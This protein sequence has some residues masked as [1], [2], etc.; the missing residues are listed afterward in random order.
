M[1]EYKHQNDFFLT[2]S[3][4]LVNPVNCVGVSGKGLALEFK[5]RYPDNFKKYQEKCHKK[6]LIIG[7]IYLHKTDLDFPKH[8]LNVPTKIHWKNK[9]E[10]SFIMKGI[11]AIC[12]IIKNYEIKSINIPALGCGLGGLEKDNV[13]EIII[14]RMENINCKIYLFGF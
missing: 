3:Q 10:Y 1:I 12:A 9:S 7:T 2:Y 13:K 11:D 8:I 5:E 6:Q 14:E 4:A